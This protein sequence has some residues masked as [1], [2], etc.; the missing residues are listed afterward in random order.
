M[1]YK[2]FLYPFA[3]AGDVA[4]VPNAVQPD[5]SVSYA[6][7]FSADYEADPAL[8]PD[9]KDIPRTAT[10]QILLDIT[11]AIQQYQQHGTPPFI[12]TSDNGGSP[13]A[14]S[15]NDRVR[16]DDGGGFK[17]Y[18]SLINSNTDLPTVSTSWA[19]VDPS[20]DRKYLTSDTTFYVRVDGNNANSGL[21]N[22]AGGAWLT[23]QHAYDALANNYDLRGYTATVNVGNGTYTSG[24]NA[25]HPN[26]T[27]FIKF[28]GNVATPNNCLVSVTNAN[29]FNASLGSI[30]YIRGFGMQ[31]TTNGGAIATTSGGKIIVDGNVQFNALAAG[32]IHLFASGSGSFIQ[33]NSDYI[34]NGG[35]A[36]HMLADYGS[37]IE[38]ANN[39]TFTILGNPNFSAFYAYSSNAASIKETGATFSGTAT[40]TRY[41]TQFNGIINTNSGGNPNYFPG[42]AAGSSLTGGQYT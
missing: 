8:D 37:F 9:A 26:T 20:S 39:L 35:A 36:Y 41:R 18:Q 3:D 14:Y 42:N 30:F 16:Y 24:I 10:N 17:V 21:A 28:V 7:G 40:G 31:T 13:Y 11:T 5:G 1:A 29:C 34:I 15:K 22:N 23:L 33:I 4:P 6:Q 12:T 32:N 27:G 19:V 2:Y 25:T 38:S